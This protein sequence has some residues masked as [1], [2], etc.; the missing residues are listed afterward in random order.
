MLNLKTKSPFWGDGNFNT[1]YYG[2]ELIFIRKLLLMAA[3]IVLSNALNAAIYYVSATGNDSNSGTSINAPWQT[4]AKVNSLTPNPGDQILFR[5]GDTWTG[6]IIIRASGTFASPIIYGAYGTGVNPVI[7]GFTTI[8]GWIYDGGGIY[9]KVINPVSAPNILII[10]GVQYSIGRYPNN[11]NLVYEASN[12]NISITDNQLPGT[13]NWTGAEAVIY[14]NAINTLDR[15]LITNHSGNTLTYTNLGTT[16]N[17]SASGD[18]FIQNDLR[19][20]DQFG[21]WYYN[22]T[23]KKLSVFFGT[24]NPST[25]ITKVSLYDNLVTN[26]SRDYIA[27]S[28]LNFE[29]SNSSTFNFR[30]GTDNCKVNNCN[31]IFSGYDAFTMFGNNI[32]IDNCS[33]SNVNG[34]GIVING[35]NALITNNNLSNIGLLPGQTNMIVSTC[36][37]TI[38]GNNPEVRFNSI[39][40][41]AYMG[42]YFTVSA[43]KGIIQYNK[44]NRTSQLRI[45]SGSIYLGHDHTGTLIDHNIVLNAGGSGIFLDEDCVGVTVSNNSVSTSFDNGIKLHISP[46]NIIQSNILYNN[47]NGIYYANWF[48]SRR[49]YDIIFADNIVFANTGQ[50]VTKLTN[51]Y[52]V[53]NNIGPANNNYYAHSSTE[54]QVFKVNVVGDN[55]NK[56]FLQWKNII[57]SDYTSYDIPKNLNTENVAFYYNDTSA[58]KSFNLNYPMIDVKGTKYSNNVT[59][60]PY[61]STILFKDPNPI[62]SDLTSPIINSFSIPEFNNSLIVPVNTFSASDN[63]AVNGYLLTESATSPSVNDTRWTASAPTFYTF[64]TEGTKTLYAWAKD[65]AGNVSASLNDRVIITLPST[66][67]NLLGYTEVYNNTISWGNQLAM[68]VTFSENG[69]ITSISIYHEGGSGNVILG[70]YSDQS[71]SPNSRLGLTSST[72]VNPSAGWQTISLSGTISVKSGQTVWLSWVFQNNPGIRY[73]EGAPG[74]AAS[75]NT[76]VNG[77]PSSFGTSTISNNKYSIYC[78]YKTTESSV[79]KSIGNTEVYDNV[80]N[81]ANQL[82]M[83]VTLTETGNINS[84][85]IYH[86]GGTGNLLLAVY[87]DQNGYPSSRLGITASTIINSTAGWQTISLISPVEV[88]SGQKVWLSWVFQN[89]PGIRYISGT[90]GRAASLNTWSNGMPSSFGTSTIANT[91]YSIYCNFIS[92]NDL[93]DITKPVVTA[94]TIPAASPSLL[95][96]ISSFTASDNR[97]VT[98]YKI[99]ETNITPLA[100]DAGWSATAPVSYSFTS[101]GTKTLYAW[102]KDA[103]GNISNTVS[104]EVLITLPDVTKPLVTSF[105]IPTS[106]T[107]LL[108]NIINFSATDNKSVTGYKLTETSITPLAGDAGWST[109][110]PVSY[111]ISSEGTKTIYAWV[112]DAAGNVS[113]SLSAQI[114]ISLPGSDTYSL[115]NT[116]VY[117]L[118]NAVSWRRAMPFTITEDGNIESI[119]IYH[120][121]GTGNLLL[122]VYADNSGSPGALLGVTPSTSVSGAE[123]WQTVTLSSPVSA[124]SGQ[125]VWLAWVFQNSVEVRFTSGSPSRGQSG[126]TWADGMPAFFGTSTIGTTKFSIYC[127][128]TKEIE[129]TL[130][131]KDLGN[132]DVYNQENVISFRRAMPFTFNEDGDIQSISIY[133]NG[134]SGNMLLGVYTDNAGSPG[135]LLGVTPS[136]LVNVTEGWQT[137][138]LSRP[139]YVNSGQTVWLAW[140]F[141]NSVRVRFTSGAPSRAQSGET[142]SAGMPTSFGT[143]TIGTNKFSIFCTYSEAA[144][145]V[146]N[147]DLGNNEVYSLV[148]A[149]Y[150]RRAMPFTFIENGN[151]QSISIYHN[152]GTGNML[153]GV[154]TDNSG[155]PGSL[156][157]VTSSTVVSG[158]E[159]WQT[160]ALSS[161]VSVNSGQTVWLAWVFQNSVG[162]RFTSGAPARAQSGATWSAGMP[163]TFGASTIGTNKFSIYCTYTVNPNILK[164]GTLTEVSENESVFAISSGAENKISFEISENSI[165]INDFRLYPN[166]ANSVI[167]VDFSEIPE[168]G[169]MI[170]IIDSYGRT[171][172]KKLAETLSNKIDIGNIP[173]GIYFV[174]SANENN[175]VVKKLIIK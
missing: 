111:S 62:F 15:C 129:P 40:N 35:L 106:S 33:V 10:D 170:E 153:M 89:N 31:V 105:S 115:G 151:I 126:E 162:V 44:L 41:T 161:P 152:G 154:Y 69:E 124:I 172:Y 104:D 8:T 47:T 49:L 75:L 159:G 60:P 63:I 85:S 158:K 73:T 78:N 83:P 160:V 119:S 13:P 92:E 17:A 108:I 59:I 142:W 74:R 76:W 120:N 6:T 5:R 88:V 144:P 65:A 146:T 12:T 118:V 3:L 55:S 141:Q 131:T 11:S 107:S 21:E 4:L 136:T 19:T 130:T 117:N 140:V 45:D 86:E 123:G 147:K 132:T 93:P 71:G 28:N 46:E 113:A 99:S 165:Y 24:I 37:M 143:S 26:S 145:P 77:M 138:T 102:T 70:V 109:T 18:Y 87:S 112:K 20:L 7:S 166:P 80:I 56:T 53:D 97:A 22:K 103:S 58:P 171:I 114:V 81:W 90:P 91:K 1:K 122:G 95:V 82:A 36:A 52:V 2:L 139:V 168:R 51:R 25:K 32:L 135:S 67:T 16:R 84:I 9:S 133:H 94:F 174:R 29:G 173:V 50:F 57:K 61:Y 98:G 127:T 100:G 134:G 38:N 116:D 48:T 128:Y 96:E 39:E 156:L 137:I 14:K 175:S 148:N 121:G 164:D 54:S 42:I 150:S 34:G 30:S 155:L 169:T 79:S 23:T 125:T 149:A 167:N 66:N 157:G 72:M 163:A 43:I 27:I 68:P 64:S 110:V 101:E